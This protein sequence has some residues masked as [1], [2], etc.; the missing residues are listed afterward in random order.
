PPPKMVARERHAKRGG[1][2][3]ASHTEDRPLRGTVA[4]VTGA[5]RG[6]G[7]GVALE[8]GAAGATV[9]VTGRSTRAEP[10]GTY[11][12]ILSLSGLSALPGSIDETA[13][14]VSAEGG[15]G[16][17]VRCDHTREDDVRRL[18]ERVR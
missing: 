15:E 12:R 2:I 1:R 11:E 5:S 14:Q 3:M 9:Y 16:I 18:F 8:L 4:V 17:A 6:A 13:E 10:A 7:R